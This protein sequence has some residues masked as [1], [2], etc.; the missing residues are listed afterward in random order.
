[1]AMR[2]IL[3]LLAAAV[4][5]QTAAQ[6]AGPFQFHAVTPCRLVDTRDGSGASNETAGARSNPGP[7]TFRAQGFCGIPSGAQAV[8]ANF[9]VVTP[10]TGGDLR[11]FPS[12]VGT[13]V[14]SVMNYNAGETAIC[15][16]AIV[17]LAQ[18]AGDD[19]AIQIGMAC[20]SP[21]GSA[22]CGSIQ[23]LIDVTGYFQ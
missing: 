9:T 17:P 21:P 14:V 10:S 3:V 6:A 15:N 23:L 22:G 8:T 16:G 7:H 13:P 1:M 20:G 19:L 4:A 5:S 18:V 11:V 2:K 12:N